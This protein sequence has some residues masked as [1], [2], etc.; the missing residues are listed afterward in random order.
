MVC[1]FGTHT[2][3]VRWAQKK[4]PGHPATART[5]S[6]TGDLERGSLD[7]VVTSVVATGNFVL[8]LQFVQVLLDLRT[9][10]LAGG[11]PET[12]VFDDLL[13]FRDLEALGVGGEIFD[14]LGPR[15]GST[16]QH[17]PDALPKTD[18]VV[19]VPVVGLDLAALLGGSFLLR[20]GLGIGLSRRLFRRL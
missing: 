1:Q 7:D 4:E 2:I 5:L 16:I 11:F 9:D 12:F 17:V 10:V 19:V 15:I 14:G 3:K 6:T 13:D 20:R 18:L 8:L